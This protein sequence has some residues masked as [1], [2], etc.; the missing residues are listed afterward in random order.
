MD[1]V[2]AVLADEPQLG[3]I[4]LCDSNHIHLTVGPLSITLAPDVFLQIA[5]MVHQANDELEKIKLLT[6]NES[7]EDFL[8]PEGFTHSRFTN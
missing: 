5:K 6:E 8:L 4:H 2:K 3:R 1:E 7:D